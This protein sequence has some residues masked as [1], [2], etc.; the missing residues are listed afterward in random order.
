MGCEHAANGLLC[1]SMTNHLPTKC[2]NAQM[3]KGVASILKHT[4]GIRKEKKP[5][6]HTVCMPAALLSFMAQTALLMECTWLKLRKGPSER[7]QQLMHVVL[8]CEQRADASPLVHDSCVLISGTVTLLVP[9]N[10]PQQ[11][12]HTHVV[13]ARRKVTCACAC[14]CVQV[15]KLGSPVTGVQLSPS[16]DLLATCHV[17]RRGIYLWYNHLMFGSGADIQPSTRPVTAALPSIATGQS[18]HVA[19][20]LVSYCPASACLFRASL[21][22]TLSLSLWRGVRNMQAAWFV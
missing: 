22:F 17:K 13:S 3:R 16:Q 6:Y 7:S 1:L 15:V 14:V 2:T 8:D 4:L 5:A 21:S 12:T 9:A 10:K 11:H 18:P 19:Q 20:A